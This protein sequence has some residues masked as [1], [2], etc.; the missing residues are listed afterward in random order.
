[1]DFTMSLLPH[2]LHC[3]APALQTVALSNVAGFAS[4]LANLAFNMPRKNPVTPGPIIDYDLLL[5]V[6]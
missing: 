5:L 1:L 3:P 2:T 4:A 6:G